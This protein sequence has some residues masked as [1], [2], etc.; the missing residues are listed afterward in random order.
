MQVRLGR[1]TGG[2]RLQ[3]NNVEIS[4]FSLS[5]RFI[6]LPLQ[7]MDNVHCRKNC[8]TLALAQKAVANELD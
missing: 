1:A 5:V 3:R 8:L 4:L 2:Q 7:A 6:V